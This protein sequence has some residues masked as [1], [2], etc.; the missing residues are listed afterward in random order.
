MGQNLP[1][2][3]DQFATL[4]EGLVQPPLIHELSDP[5]DNKTRTRRRLKIAKS[6]LVKKR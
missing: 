6:K 5:V 4:F 1:F 2:V 3:G